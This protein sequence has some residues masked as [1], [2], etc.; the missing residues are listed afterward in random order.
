MTAQERRAASADHDQSYPAGFPA[1]AWAVVRGLATGTSNGTGVPLRIANVV[2]RVLLLALVG[3]FAFTAPWPG[4]LEGSLQVVAFAVAAIV[5]AVWMPSERGPARDS[6]AL[7]WMLAALVLLSGAASAVPSG[8]L[9]VILGVTAMVSAGSDAGLAVGTAVLALGVLGTEL[10]GLLLDAGTTVTIEYPIVLLLG[11]VFGRN[12]Q[13]QRIRAEQAERLR[14]EQ[15]SVAVLDERARIAREIHDVL[16]HSLGAL[17]VQ[18]QLA[19]AVLVHEHDET[20]AVALLDRARRMTTEGLTETR[21]AV[22]ALRGD[23][24]PLPEALS[25]LCTDHRQRHGT[26]VT[27][28]VTGEPRP[29]KADAALALTRTAQEALV[30]AAKHSPRQSVDVH[31]RYAPA[32]TGLTIANRL[33][34]PTDVAPMLST[35]DGWYGLTGMRER[36]LLLDGTLG[37]G[38][39]GDHWIVD[40]SV[41]G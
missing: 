10:A 27:L 3:S 33:A 21:R 9:F 30:N 18:I 7:P 40:A 5:L 23:S 36:I 6:R 16:A 20:H 24:R 17:S 34:R 12:V 1:V 41:P 35:I 31:L 29:L 32:S 37:A 22:Q 2:V 25:R 14:E 26:A 8:S 39:Q 38:P 11:F 28:Q 13:A 19:Q 4:A 15:A